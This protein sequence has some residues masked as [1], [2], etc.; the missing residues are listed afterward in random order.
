MSRPQYEVA[1][2]LARF[3]SQLA[4]E[5][6]PNTYQ[7]RVLR[8][9]T[10]CRTAELGGHKQA[11]TCCGRE[12]ISYN[13][14]RNRHCPKCQ[15]AKQAAWV[16]E[17]LET[18]LPVK[19]YHVVFTV[20][21]A[22]NALCLLDSAGFY[23]RLFAAAW[24]TLRTF[25]YT[26][27]GVESGAVCVL[28]T[29]GQNLS[30]HPHLH[31]IVPAA[32]ET[33]DGRLK[34]IGKGGKFLYSVRQLGTVFRGKLMASMQQNLKKQ[35]LLEQHR[36]LLAAAWEKPWVV[37]CEPSLA[38]PEHV[39]RYL[40]QYAH[41]VAITNQRILSVGDQ[42]VTFLHT[43]YADGAKQKP[44]TLPGVEFLRRFCLHILPHGFVKIRRYGIY[45]SRARA[46]RKKEQPMVI[47]K[48]KE[49]PQARLLRLTG[50]DVYQCPF[51]KRGTMVTV[52]ELPRVRSPE[53]QWSAWPVT[54]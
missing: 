19:H 11:C 1:D 14:C 49:T 53:N 9:L 16:E 37:F 5:C 7:L 46:A 20:P 13:S 15:G 17:L 54:A 30:L 47:G 48:P 39:V 21:H 29:W 52:E 45:S 25:G 22:L 31:C 38:K 6:A 33:P 51:C 44:T 41:R 43:D 24:D 50:F 28:H 42:G 27:F 4:A 3:G 10:L 32:G 8:A 12:R 18:T 26:G 34:P 40:G 35:G 36:P 23:N 2:I